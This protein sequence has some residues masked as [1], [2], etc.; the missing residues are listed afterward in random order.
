MRLDA[1]WA[2]GE[3]LGL[4]GALQAGCRPPAGYSLA[5]YHGPRAESDAQATDDKSAERAERRQMWDLCEGCAG[6]VG[7]AEERSVMRLWSAGL[8]TFD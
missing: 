2:L 8:K 3:L 1:E 7:E 6:N 4:E 5:W